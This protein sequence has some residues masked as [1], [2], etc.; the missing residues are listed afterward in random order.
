[1]TAYLLKLNELRGATQKTQT[2]IWKR[3][4]TLNATMKQYWSKYEPI[5]DL[6]K[7]DSQEVALENLKS[8]PE[9]ERE[10]FLKSSIKL[11]EGENKIKETYKSKIKDLSD[12]IEEIGSELKK[13]A[14]INLHSNKPLFDKQYQLI[15]SLHSFTIKRKAIEVSEDYSSGLKDTLRLTQEILIECYDFEHLILVELKKL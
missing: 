9:S 14:L 6:G 13:E 2:E 3:T 8:I 5:L 1:M 15:K 4:E 11:F 10:K 12:R 7:E